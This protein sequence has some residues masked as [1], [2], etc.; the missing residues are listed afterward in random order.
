[1]RERKRRWLKSRAREGDS[2]PDKERQ[3]KNERQSERQRQIERELRERNLEKERGRVEKGKRWG[4][5]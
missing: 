3:R 5:R 2:Q 1:M 4:D